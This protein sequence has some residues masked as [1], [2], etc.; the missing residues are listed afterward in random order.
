[1]LYCPPPGLDYCPIVVHLEDNLALPCGPAGP[2]RTKNPG[3]YFGPGSA[4]GLH[5]ENHRVYFTPDGAA[6]AHQEKSQGYMLGPTAPQAHT[7]KIRG[8]IQAVSK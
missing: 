8:C 7:R 3:V 4:A 5:Q 2:G 6:G 1:M